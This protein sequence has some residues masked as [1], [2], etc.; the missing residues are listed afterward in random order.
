MKKYTPLLLAAATSGMGYGQTTAYT[1]PVGYISAKIAASGETFIASTL[2]APDS[3]AG[4]TTNDPSGIKA[5]TIASTLPVDVSPLAFYLEITSGANE[6]WWSTITALTGSTTIT[7]NDTLPSGLAVGTK[8]AVRAHQTLKGMFG[9]NSA[10]LVTGID[11]NADEVQ[12]LDPITQKITAFFYASQTD[13]NGASL[14]GQISPGWFDGSGAPSDNVVI[15]PG[16]AVKVVHKAPGNLSLVVAGAVKTTKTQIDIY[17]GTNFVA[18]MLAAGTTLGATNLDT[19][20]INTGLK[21]GVDLSVDEIQLI[22]TSQVVSPYFCADP[23]AAPGYSGFYDGAGVSF[24]SQ[25]VPEWQ[26][27]IIIR[28]IPTPATWTAPAQVIAQ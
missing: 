28:K 6:G 16:S 18:P 7:T 14:T 24:N 22:S 17:Q 19:G 10:G 27:A 12:L 11:L 21:R 8:I 25:F 20:N 9:A 3:F 1:T 15:V 2:V 5:V 13:I 23:V 26:G 4:V